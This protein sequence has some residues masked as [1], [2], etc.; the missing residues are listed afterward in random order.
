MVQT[1]GEAGLSG[2]IIAKSTKNSSQKATFDIRIARGM[3]ITFTRK[4]R[5]ALFLRR[6]SIFI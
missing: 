2:G 1:K 5:P 6:K 4:I 3:N